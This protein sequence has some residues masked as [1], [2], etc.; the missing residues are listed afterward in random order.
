[1]PAGEGREVAEGE[2]AHAL[3]QEE[4]GAPGESGGTGRGD[5]KEPGT[6]PG[7]G[8]FLERRR[9]RSHR[10]CSE[11]GRADALEWVPVARCHPATS[12][13]LYACAESSEGWNLCTRRLHLPQAC[14]C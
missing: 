7:G 6:V 14:R 2:R 8:A 12:G 1:M 11:G 13:T 5:G 4:P 9:A 10:P 3:L